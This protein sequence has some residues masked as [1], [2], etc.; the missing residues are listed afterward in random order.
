MPTTTIVAAVTTA[1]IDSTGII[2]HDPLPVK[3]RLSVTLRRSTVKETAIQHRKK[4]T[5]LICVVVVALF[6]A[7]LSPFDA[8]IMRLVPMIHGY[9][10]QVQLLAMMC[11]LQFRYRD[12]D[13]LR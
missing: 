7:L 9:T 4:M 8:D 10:I 6:C 2:A 12:L 1:S 5:S 13:L 3:E 11:V